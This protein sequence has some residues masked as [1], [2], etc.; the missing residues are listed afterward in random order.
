MKSD[1]L[2]SRSRSRESD[3]EICWSRSRESDFKICWSLSRAGV[4]P[5]W[6]ENNAKE[7]GVGVRVEEVGTF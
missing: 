3:F 6:P 1:F 2:G 7:S 4:G 5:F